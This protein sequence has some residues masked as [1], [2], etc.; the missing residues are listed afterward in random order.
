MH[1]FGPQDRS[2]APSAAAQLSAE[3]AFGTA[4]GAGSLAA[5]MPTPSS[6]SAIPDLTVTDMLFTAKKLNGSLLGADHKEGTDS[7][8]GRARYLRVHANPHV[9]SCPR[10]R[11]DN[12]GASG[13]TSGNT[14]QCTQACVPTWEPR[15]IAD[16]PQ[17]TI[18]QSRF[19]CGVAGYAR[20]CLILQECVLAFCSIWSMAA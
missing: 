9:Q 4:I 16:T 6:C 17:G 14:Q 2:Q 1:L 19:T 13:D 8:G 7:P 12:F 20:R 15:A 18:E 10:R 5:W 11:S 3:L